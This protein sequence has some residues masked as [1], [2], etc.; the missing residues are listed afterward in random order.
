[1]QSVNLVAART[2]HVDDV[3][4]ATAAVV[5]LSVAAELDSWQQTVEV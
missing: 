3:A 1:M 2:Q 5:P 4:A